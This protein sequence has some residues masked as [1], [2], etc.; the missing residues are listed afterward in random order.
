MFK[1]RLQRAVFAIYTGAV[2]E[3]RFIDSF[4][5]PLPAC[6]SANWPGNSQEAIRCF[7]R[8]AT[9]PSVAPHG[10]NWVLPQAP[11]RCSPLGA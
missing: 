7:R 2:C 11:S 8:N 4:H 9:S 1:N 6:W 3:W 10:K 5:G